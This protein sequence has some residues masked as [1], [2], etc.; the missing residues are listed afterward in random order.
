M[1]PT[2]KKKNIHLTR[3][4]AI[5]LVKACNCRDCMNKGRSA[6]NTK[7]ASCIVLNCVNDVL[8]TDVTLACKDTN[9]VQT[10]ESLKKLPTLIGLEGRQ[11]HVGLRLGVLASFLI[12][13]ALKLH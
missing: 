9:S 3:V 10:S 8:S 5:G 4:D 1:F 7:C 13:I 11:I 12:N 2:R 6:K